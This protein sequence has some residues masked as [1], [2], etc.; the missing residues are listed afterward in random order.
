MARNLLLAFIA[1]IS[2]TAVDQFIMM[3][4]ILMIFI[5]CGFAYMPWKDPRLAQ[6]DNAVCM[7]VFFAINC[8]IG[9]MH[10]NFQKQSYDRDTSETAL[11]AVKE[12]DA[13]IY[14][15]RMLLIATLLVVFLLFASLVVYCIWAMKYMA[16]LD[17]REAARHELLAGRFNELFDLAGSDVKPH[18]LG[19]ITTGT[20][21]DVMNIKVFLDNME[22]RI[23]I[24]GGPDSSGGS[25]SRSSKRLRLSVDARDS[26]LKKQDAALAC[27]DV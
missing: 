2:S 10:L 16:K 18:F 20:H 4:V 22:E 7:C 9:F 26:S 23:G 3:A 17:A 19:Y 13:R 1:V 14:V 8:G 15:F 11:K 27:A 5:V 12:I 24:S 6:F 25:A 21:Y